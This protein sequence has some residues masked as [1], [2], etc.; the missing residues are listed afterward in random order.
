D[1]GAAA[2]GTPEVFVVAVGEAALAAGL[3]LAENLRDGRPGLR[4]EMNC[5]GGGFKAQMRRADASGAAVALILGEDEAS[6]GTVGVK[7]LRRTGDPQQTVG[8]DGALAA[9]LPLLAGR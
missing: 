5:G 6:A 3:R 1:G 9:L 2:D 7:G 4:I 8:Q